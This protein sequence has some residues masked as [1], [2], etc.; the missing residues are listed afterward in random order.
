MFLKTGPRFKKNVM[1]NSAE[2]EIL[3]ARKYENIR[4]F[5]SDK[6]RMLFF[7]LINGKIPT[8]VGIFVSPAKQKGDICT[9]FPAA[10]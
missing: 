8:I 7:L 4:K 10:A 9:A 1:L 3:N 6:L 2:L 5:S